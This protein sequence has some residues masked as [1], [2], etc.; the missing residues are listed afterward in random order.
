VRILEES[1]RIGEQYTLKRSEK[2]RGVLKGD[3]R[4]GNEDMDP[5]E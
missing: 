1:D 2:V 5:E 4:G 3:V